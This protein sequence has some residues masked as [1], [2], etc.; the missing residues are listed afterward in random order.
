MRV[1][2]IVWLQAALGSVVWLAVAPVAHALPVRISYT[3]TGGAFGGPPAVGPITGGSLSVLYPGATNTVSFFGTLSITRLL[4][5]GP[6]G[7]VSW[8]VPPALQGIPGLGSFTAN[9]HV[10]KA[11]LNTGFSG[12]FFS[13]T[14]KAAPFPATLLGNPSLILDAVT[15]NGSATA[16]WTAYTA[17]GTILGQPTHLFRVGSEVRALI[18]E[19]GTGLLLGIGLTALAAVTRVG[20]AHQR[21]QRRRSRVER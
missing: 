6:S 19:P 9:K 4:V 21:R 5:T 18:P 13:A 15:G 17:G 12:P 3:L 20:A 14:G 2:R 16:R 10:V 7:F 1:V 8:A 11:V